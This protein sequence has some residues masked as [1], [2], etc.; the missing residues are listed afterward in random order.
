M[1]LERTAKMADL[2]YL[3]LLAPQSSRLDRQFRATEST[4]GRPH[5]SPVRA[6]SLARGIDLEEAIGGGRGGASPTVPRS[7]R[8]APATCWGMTEKGFFPGRTAASI[9]NRVPGA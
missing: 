9:L 7:R 8:I 1:A 6:A 2:V 3:S 5:S 4:P